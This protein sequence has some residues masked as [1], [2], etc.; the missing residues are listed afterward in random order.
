MKELEEQFSFTPASTSP[1]DTAKY[2]LISNPSIL[3]HDSTKYGGGYAPGVDNGDGTFTAHIARDNLIDAMQ[4]C[5]E[6]AA[7][8]DSKNSKPIKGPGKR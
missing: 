3:I 4:K 5:I 1:L 8:G 7:G 6:I 2:V